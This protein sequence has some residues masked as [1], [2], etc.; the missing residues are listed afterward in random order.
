MKLKRWLA[1][2]VNSFIN[3]TKTSFT[4]SNGGGVLIEGVGILFGACSFFP[5][6]KIANNQRNL[7]L[8]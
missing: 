7:I 6:D 2:S 4:D 3:G 5:A 8:D 1:P